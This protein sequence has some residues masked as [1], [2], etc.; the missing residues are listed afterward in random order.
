[1]S[2][3]VYF[4]KKM[5]GSFMAVHENLRLVMGVGEEPQ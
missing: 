5:L 1:M 4:Q 3:K 2:Q